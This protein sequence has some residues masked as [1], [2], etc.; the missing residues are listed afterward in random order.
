MVASSGIDIWKPPSPTMENTSL[1]GRAN[2]APM[3]AGR[4]KPMEPRPPELIHSRGELKRMNCAAHI[5]CWP[6]SEVTMARPPES[7]SISRITCCGLIS[8]VDTSGVSGCSA[9]H[10]RICRH[11]AG[12]RGAVLFAALRRQFLQNLGQLLEH[13]LDVAHDGQVGRAV[14]ADFGRIDIHVNHFGMRRERRQAA[15]HAIVKAHAQSDQQ[16]GVRHAHVGR[17]AA[18]HARHADVVGML[19]RQAAQAH[20]RGDRGRVDQFHQFA[21]F[22]RRVGRDNAAARINKRPLA[23]PRS[24]A[25]RAGSGRCGLR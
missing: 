20:Q 13:A 22:L 9:F 21:Q 6:T 3:A 23:I 14:L 11:H 17:V 10:S 12:A 16:I 15:G 1:S 19:G 2:C 25:P 5:W 24:S 7:R 4:P 18:M 8:L